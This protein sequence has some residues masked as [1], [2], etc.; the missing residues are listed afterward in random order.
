[1]RSLVSILAVGQY[2]SPLQ[3]D[4]AI[5]LRWDFVQMVGDKHNGLALLDLCAYEV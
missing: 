3:K 5:D 2:L 1:M 4:H